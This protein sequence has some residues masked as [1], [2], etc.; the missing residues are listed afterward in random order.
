MQLL[1]RAH[2][3]VRAWHPTAVI[4]VAIFRRSPPFRDEED[5]VGRREIEPIADLASGDVDAVEAVG[6]LAH[7]PHFHCNGRQQRACPTTARL[8]RVG[9]NDGLL[10]GC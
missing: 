5:G 8:G 1:R 2:E 4:S 9:S 10:R 6:E 7:Q 3:L